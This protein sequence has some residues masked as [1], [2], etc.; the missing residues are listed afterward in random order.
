MAINWVMIA[1]AM[2]AVGT[3]VSAGGMIAQGQ[4]ARRQAE[5]QAAQFRAQAERDRQIAKMEADDYR[6]RQRR[7]LSTNIAAMGGSGVEMG[8]GTPLLVMADFAAEVE[9][10]A[11][12]VEAGGEDKA[13]KA[14]NAARMAQMRGRDA[15][16]AGVIS[17][18]GSLFAGGGQLAWMGAKASQ[19]G[20]GGGG[21]GLMTTSTPSTTI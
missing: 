18:L 2:S 14:E 7:A 12:K 15:A 4:Q 1:M 5:L 6:R 20:G 9:Y 3:I 19:Y 21:G 16:R 8:T 13:S 17:G 10:N 11:L